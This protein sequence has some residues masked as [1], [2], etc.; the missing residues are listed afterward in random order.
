MDHA[1][2][3]LGLVSVPAKVA[4]ILAIDRHEGAVPENQLILQHGAGGLI[5]AEDVEGHAIQ[6]A[7]G[8]PGARL[9]LEVWNILVHYAHRGGAGPE[10][11]GGNGDGLEDLGHG[12]DLKT[13]FD[14]VLWE[15]AALDARLGSGVPLSELLRRA[16]GVRAR[17][18]FCQGP[19]HKTRLRSGNWSQAV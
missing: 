13:G 8:G 11:D 3:D 6:R 5:H 1:V 15:G 2:D 7:R 18:R 9:D 14:A 12:R 4:I 17:R 10:G 16:P 19:R